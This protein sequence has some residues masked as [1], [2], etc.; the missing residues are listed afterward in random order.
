MEATDPLVRFDLSI[1]ERSPSP[2]EIPYSVLFPSIS[3]FRFLQLSF[4]SFDKENKKDFPSP[5]KYSS[6]F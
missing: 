4:V 1:M 6:L 3:L 5:E 2:N